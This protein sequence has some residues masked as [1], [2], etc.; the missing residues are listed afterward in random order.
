MFSIST[1]SSVHWPSSALAR[2]TQFN[3][4]NENSRGQCILKQKGPVKTKTVEQTNNWCSVQCVHQAPLRKLCFTHPCCLL[5]LPTEDS[6]C[7][8]RIL[9]AHKCSHQNIKYVFPPILEYQPILP[10]INNLQTTFVKVLVFL[11]KEV[12]KPNASCLS[13]WFQIST[14]CSECQQFFSSVVLGLVFIV[15]PPPVSSAFFWLS[16]LGKKS[17]GEARNVSQAKLC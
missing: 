10:I 13:V 3:S 15:R 11:P 8:G 17:L 7:M 14:F 1:T 9:A 4:A 16:H 5:K 6:T 12:T 2:F